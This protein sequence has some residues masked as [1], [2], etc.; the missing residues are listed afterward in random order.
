M[1]QPDEFKAIQQEGEGNLLQEQT[2]RGDQNRAAQGDSSLFLQGDGNQ[3][4]SG[5]KNVL[6]KG[7]R[8]L[9]FSSLVNIEVWNLSS[10]NLSVSLIL[11]AI[12]SVVVL[13]F[14]FLFQTSNNES[15]MPDIDD[16]SPEERL[17]MD[18][19]SLLI[20]GDLDEAE[21]RISELTSLSPDSPD[22]LYLKSVLA[23]ERNNNRAS[24]EY[25]EKALERS[26]N[27]VP[28][29]TQKV[30][31]LLLMGGRER[32]EAAVIARE[33]YGVSTELDIWLECLTEN[34]F[35]QLLSVTDSE[36]HRECP[37]PLGF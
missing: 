4:V 5:E 12:F 11:S 19:H 16:I 26:P 8:N 22:P 10:S 25:V 2:I 1:V 29:I 13:F 18:V 34:E 33:S 20:D 24:L 28:S 7:N 31:I 35:F 23:I 17:L 30:R 36:L 37:L 15:N 14:F 27:H 21:Q 6:V 9:T 32:D 3:G